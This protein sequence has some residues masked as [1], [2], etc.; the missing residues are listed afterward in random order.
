MPKHAVNDIGL[1][2]DPELRALELHLGDLVLSW[3]GNRDNPAPQAEIVE[4]YHTT[5]NKLYTLGWDGP[6][7]FEVELPTALMPPEYFKHLLCEL[8]SHWRENPE[9]PVHRAGIIKAYYRALD[10]LYT[11]GWDG[12]LE[13]DC[14]L[15]EELMPEEYRKRSKKG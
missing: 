1:P 14:Q 5:L 7:D 10:E 11:T 12:E 9:D 3:W 13:S 15:P 6:L 2:L 8:A 4:E